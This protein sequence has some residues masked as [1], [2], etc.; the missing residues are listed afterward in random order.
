MLLDQFPVL[1]DLFSPFI[2]AIMKGDISSYDKLLDVHERRLVEMNLLLTL[3]RGREL[4]I[5]RLFRRVYVLPLGAL[6]LEI[7]S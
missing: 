6:K 7:R 4:C 5:R 2:A 1:D 3:E